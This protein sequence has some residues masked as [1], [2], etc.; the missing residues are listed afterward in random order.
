MARNSTSYDFKKLPKGCVYVWG[1]NEMSELGLGAMLSNV[2]KPE[3]LV[4]K[5]KKVVALSAGAHHNALVT[6]SGELFTWGLGKHGQLGMGSK[7][8]NYIPVRVPALRKKKVLSVSC[9]EKCTVCVVAEKAGGQLYSWGQGPLGLERDE[10]ALE[11]LQVVAFRGK[12]V[13]GA[14]CGSSHSVSIIQNPG[15]DTEVYTWGR[16]GRSE[17]SDEPLPQSI[18]PLRAVRARQVSCGHDFSSVLTERND[19]YTWGSGDSGRLGIGSVQTLFIPMC[20]PLLSQK[21][22]VNVSLGSDHAGAV[23]DEGLVFTWGYGSNGRL[24]HGEENDILEPTVVESLASEPAVQVSCG[25]HH[26]GVVTREGQV[27][28]FG[29][30]HYGQ[31]GIGDPSLGRVNENVL[32]PARVVTLENLHV[33]RLECGEQHTIALVQLSS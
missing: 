11:P 24:G 32:L 33:L 17:D 22:V 16:G 20:V 1:C 5:K 7:K 6:S 13:I 23:T 3:P 10:P 9:G 27:F 26:T 18:E 28:M 15:G 21:R 30:N 31:L 2:F 19:L 8:S 25:G 14:A 12:N 29:W 4:L